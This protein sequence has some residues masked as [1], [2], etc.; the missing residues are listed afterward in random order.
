MAIQTNELLRY[1]RKRIRQLYPKGCGD[2][3]PIE[4]SKMTTAQRMQEASRS[5]GRLLARAQWDVFEEIKR[6]VLRDM[7]EDMR[8]APYIL[9]AWVDGVYFY[10]LESVGWVKDHEAAKTFPSFFEAEAYIQQ[11]FD[12]N[13]ARDSI[14]VVPLMEVQKCEP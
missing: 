5:D 6:F 8:S 7:G 13:E 1:C 4:L 12:P 9:Q 10:Y 11:N 2:P 3:S 14:L